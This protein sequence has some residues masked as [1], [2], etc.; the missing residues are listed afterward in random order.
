M[1]VSYS[2]RDHKG[3]F[4]QEHVGL[5]EKAWENNYENQS[6]NKTDFGGTFDPIVEK[7]RNVA[8]KHVEMRKE[9]PNHPVNAHFSIKEMQKQSLIYGLRTKWEVKNSLY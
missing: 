5:R 2:L 1:D 6:E 4:F 7:K 3:R 8:L 9:G